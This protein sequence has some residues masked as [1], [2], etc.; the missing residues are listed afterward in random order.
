MQMKA[1]LERQT[2]ARPLALVRIVVGLSAIALAVFVERSALNRL[3]GEDIFQAPA[4]SWLPTLT[5]A[6][7]DVILV[8]WIA[9]AIAL[10]IGLYAR[11]AAA[12]V[13]LVAAAAMTLDLQAFSNH[14]TLLVALSV[15]LAL[16][17]PAAAWSVDSRRRGSAASIA[18]WPVFLIK[19]QISTVYAY[20]ALS[21]INDSFLSAEVLASRWEPGLGSLTETLQPV[22]IAIAISTVL[23]EG[24]LAVGLWN[25]RL[26]RV[27]LPLGLGLH[28]L[29]PATFGAPLIPFSALMVGAYVLF[30]DWQAGSQ[31]V[32]WNSG[33]EGI[34]SFV[35]AF[36]R[37]D[38][39]GVH[40]FEPSALAPS[41]PPIR[42]SG[43]DRSA[44]GYDA[45]R[46]ML[47]R[48]P[49]TF[50]IAPILGSRVVAPLGR[51]AY[52]R[53]AGPGRRSTTPAPT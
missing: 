27:A 43:P 29:I 47:E 7:V 42:L 39:F 2:D 34:A 31:R 8:L 6:L 14:V 18:Y 51:R 45:V 36:R 22:L 35:R 3:S 24:F 32:V 4:A 40:D 21:K 16:G 1:L 38:W 49:V 9:F 25:E 5:P 23:A 20:A 19:F 12:G 33:S 10:T 52:Q 26:R 41:E 15:L 53:V 13:A 44:E 28:V 17:N 50:L 11:L 46:L 30:P 48:S 37:L